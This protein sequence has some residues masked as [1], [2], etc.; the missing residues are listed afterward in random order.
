MIQ[1]SSLTKCYIIAEIGVNHCGNVEMAKA[2]I[3]AAKEVG[4]DAVKFQTFTAEELVT[5]GTPKVR[6]QESTTSVDEDHYKMIKKLEFS[7]EDHI[8]VFEYCKELGID[9]ISTP[10]DV[11]SA[12][13]L[14]KMGVTIFKVASADIVDLPLQKYLAS[15][16]KPVIIATGMATIGEIDTVVDIYRQEQNEN[17]CLLHCVSNYPCSNESLNLKAMTTL[18]ASFQLPVGFSDHSIGDMA[19]GLSIALNA[20]VIEKHFTLDKSMPGP[21]HKASS[22]PDE[23]RLLV[24]TIRLAELMLGSPHKKCQPEEMQMAMV[25]RKSLVATR[26]I[27]A[28]EIIKESDLGLKRPG[29]GLMAAEQDRLI[30]RK[31]TRAIPLNKLISWLDV[32]EN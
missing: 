31:T 15:T 14:N 11:E 20:K 13:F 32:E 12:K 27:S 24:N 17:I 2:M 4:A 6:Y 18:A 25:S 16:K 21:D 9:F 7:R 3:L 1:F 30:G 19:A 8:P 5:Q 10:Y 23:F 26:N 22:T 29:T 28:G